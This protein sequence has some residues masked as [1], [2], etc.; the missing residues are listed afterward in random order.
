MVEVRDAYNILVG[1]PKGRRPLGIP[2]HR[3][4]DN[5]KMNL[6]EMG[7]GMWIGMWIGFIGLRIGTGGGLL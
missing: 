3:W 1:R 7:L 5:I 2:R 6:R 4:E